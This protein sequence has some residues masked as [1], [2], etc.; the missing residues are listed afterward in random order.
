M[1]RK[2]DVNIT[3]IAA[4]AG[5]SI[6]SVSRAMNGRNGVSEEVRRRVSELQK[7]HNYIGNNHLN[8][9]KKIAVVADS[10]SFGSYH[11]LLY[12]G[13]TAA[14]SHCQVEYCT[15]NRNRNS[16]RT[17][18]EEIREQQCS[19]IL[20]VVPTLF[21][22]E[23]GELQGS[24]LQVVLLDHSSGYPD[25]GFVGHDAC[26]GSYD[27]TRRLLELGHRRIGYL[28]SPLQ[29]LNHVARLNGYWNALKEAGIA[30]DPAWCVPGSL[31]SEESCNI[32]RKL[33]CDNPELTAVMATDDDFAMCVLRV[34]YEL[35]IQVPEELSV[36]GF[37]DLP[38]SRCLIPA[39]TTVRHPIH[40][41]GYL[42]MKE[43]AMTLKNPAHPLPREIL[44]TR[45][46]RRESMAAVRR[47]NR[48][49]VGTTE[50]TAPR[51]Q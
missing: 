16:R 25:F 42:A 34:A 27:A 12:A 38:M 30:A 5:L 36:I 22:K 28:Y 6:S 41:S 31:S 21:E 17:L 20:V 45:F 43:L 10:A 44:S 2:T 29:T 3:Q 33:L 15:I 11:S 32:V 23:L 50:Q 37:D 9:D 35:K 39:L 46:V 1:V 4:E 19:G 51:L 26:G 7:K 47:E 49:R 24:E 13:F 14:A 18:L 48:L 40:E 8:R